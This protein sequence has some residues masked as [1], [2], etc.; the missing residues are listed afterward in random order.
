MRSERLGDTRKR[1]SP[2]IGGQGRWTADEVMGSQQAV[3]TPGP[4]G[5]LGTR[6]GVQEPS[7]PGFS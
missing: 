2:G 5:E 4:S 3:P 1:P 7:G 6:D